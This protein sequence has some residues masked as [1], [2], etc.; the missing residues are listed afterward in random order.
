[1]ELS[2]YDEIFGFGL[3]DD[4]SVYSEEE[5]D[6]LNKFLRMNIRYLH[7]VD[8][9]EAAGGDIDSVDPAHLYLGESSDV[10]EDSSFFNAF[11]MNNIDSDEEELTQND[12]TAMEEQSFQII[13]KYNSEGNMFQVIRERY[14][15]PIRVDILRDNI[16]SYSELMDVVS[17]FVRCKCYDCNQKPF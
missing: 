12:I 2:E 15:N 1:M 13:L 11:H 8:I 3:D 6:K 17:D 14:C 9:L 5:I 16:T 7:K 4:L 10:P